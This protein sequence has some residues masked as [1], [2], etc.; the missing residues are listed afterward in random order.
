M[1]KDLESEEKVDDKCDYNSRENAQETRSNDAA[2]Y[3]R[4]ESPSTP[5]I[6]QA[7]TYFN[8]SR[9]VFN[10]ALNS[11]SFREN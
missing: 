4:I 1:E 2:D 10:S 7:Q 3:P 8:G 9:L 6:L 11:T 5:I